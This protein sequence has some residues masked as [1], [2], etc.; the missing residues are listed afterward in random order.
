MLWTFCLWRT[1]LRPN[2]KENT[3]SGNNHSQ[4]RTRNRWTTLIG[5]VVF[6]LL[7]TGC[8]GAPKTK[9]Y[10]IGVVN[11]SV[12]QESTVKGFKEGMTDLGYVEG[13]NVAYIYD[14][15]VSADQLDAVA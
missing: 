9:T 14:G 1:I 13:K 7:M 12:N 8:G 3:M 10:T 11:P 4:G 6:A 2:E 5:V 15:P